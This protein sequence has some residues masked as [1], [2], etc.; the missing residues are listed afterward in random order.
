MKLFKAIKLVRAL[1]EELAM[2]LGLTLVKML[3]KTRTPSHPPIQR[4]PNN[5]TKDEG[6][7]LFLISL[8]F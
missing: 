5:G 2:M 8:D 6:F 1:K 3:V 4:R 7:K